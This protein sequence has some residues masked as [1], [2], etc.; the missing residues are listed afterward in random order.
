MNYLNEE[1]RIT[2]NDYHFLKSILSVIVDVSQKL[3][4]EFI[5]I[6]AIARELLIK[7]VFGTDLVLRATK[8]LDLAIMIDDW[9]TYDVVK[10]DL[11]INHGFTKSD[12][13]QRLI[14]NSIPVDI[15]PFGEIAEEG[16]IYWPPDKSFK[17]S[18]TGF[19]EA[20]DSAVD[21]I[22]DA[23][24][25]R[26]LS[27]EGLFIT[28]LVAWHERKD[29][30]KTDAEDIGTII[31]HYND[32]YPDDLF[33]SYSHLIDSADY[34]FLFAGVQIFGI[35]LKKLLDDYPQLL[36]R[37]IEILNEEI[38]YEENSE[39]VFNLSNIE[40]YDTNITS[41]NIILNELLK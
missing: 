31:Y 27:L 7:Y 3:D 34:N 1:F 22:F 29:T 14:Y 40:T 26:I 20:F 8:D 28:K 11:V 18:V 17:M 9:H 13:E 38:A 16:S 2:D 33:E 36:H 21:I 39:L 25:F 24:K 37:I 4:F 10:T 5:V 19:K 12:Q 23:L 6:G 35:R 30:K 15:I 32:F 41:L